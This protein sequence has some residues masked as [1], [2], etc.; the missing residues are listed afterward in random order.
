MAFIIT[1]INV[2]ETGACQ[3]STAETWRLDFWLV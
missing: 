2:Q 1:M 3:K